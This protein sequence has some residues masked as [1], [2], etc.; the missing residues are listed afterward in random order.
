MTNYFV[1]L[2]RLINA[3]GRSNIKV[4]E[5]SKNEENEQTRNFPLARSDERYVRIKSPS[6]DDTSEI[7]VLIYIYRNEKRLTFYKCVAFLIARSRK[8]FF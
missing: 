2:F 3:F 5:R 4:I 8:K 7:D 6:R 1:L